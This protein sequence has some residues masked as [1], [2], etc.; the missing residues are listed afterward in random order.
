MQ[1]TDIPVETIL[2]VVREQKQ[3]DRDRRMALLGIAVSISL[4]FV[5]LA[6]GLPMIPPVA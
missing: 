2:K 1:D 6:G 5:A 3:A 4:G